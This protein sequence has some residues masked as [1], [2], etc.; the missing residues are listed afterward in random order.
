MELDR[1]FFYS[2]VGFLGGLYLFFMGLVWFKRKRLIE[3]IP[4]SKIR[5][6]AMGQAEVYGEVVLAE[7]KIL[8]SPFTASDC[9]YYKYTVE[10]K[11]STGK[12]SHWRTIAS[13]EYG[14][15]FYLRDDTGS[16]LVDPKGAEID[17]PVDWHVG[18]GLGQDPPESVKMFLGTQKINF[19]GFF[20]MNKT[21][22]YK[23]YYIAPGDKLYVMG[24]AG[25]NPF[26]E[27]A[28]AKSSAEDIMMQKGEEGEVYYISDRS[29]KGILNELTLKAFGGVFGG[30]A[31]AIFCLYVIL[32]YLNLF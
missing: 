11:I 25:D 12:S 9:V 28:W 4:T 13:G 31:L 1:G 10:E 29:E 22:R 21:M 30:G 17:I 6:L 8:K 23:E 19:E 24:M 3:D 32:R 16:A 18:S 5:S 20:G 27:E 2:I 14:T 26:L 15:Q 7:G